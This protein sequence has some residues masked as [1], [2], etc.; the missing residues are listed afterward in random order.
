M[1]IAT[2]T[3]TTLAISPF[4]SY[5]PIN[6]PKMLVLVTGASL[7]LVTLL[8]SARSLVG[9]NTLFVSVALALVVALIIA[10]LRNPASYAQQL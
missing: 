8:A 5:Y 4:S 9:I 6:L 3:I 10:F 1:L 7:L 2:P